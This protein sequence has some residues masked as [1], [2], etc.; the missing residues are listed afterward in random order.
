MNLSRRTIL[1]LLTTAGLATFAVTPASAGQK[2]GEKLKLLIIDGQNNHDWKATTPV[3]KSFLE[4][5]GRFD[6]SVATTPPQGASKEDWG[7]FQPEFK[8][9]DV[10]LSNYNGELW[11]ERVQESLV[12]YVSGGGGLAIVH[13]A[14]NAFPQWEEWNRMIGLGWR[15]ADFGE[16]VTL[17]DAGEVVRT[18]KGEGPGAGH[19]PQHEFAVV[20]RDRE[21]AITKGLPA[22]WMHAKDELYHGQRGPAQNMHILATAFSG[23]NCGGTGTH[24][25]MVWWI[26]YGKGRVFTTVMGHAD[27]SMKCVGFQTITARGAEWAATGKVTLPVPERFPT[28]EKTSVAE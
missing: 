1:A 25:P 17:N 4:K 27:Y 8:D 21:H 9:F 19:G 23:N 15:G 11:P 13:A 10:V 12:E 5:T 18:P 22:E 20:I 28:A 3:L 16:R 6:V 26:P 7:S 24:E 14:N 2:E